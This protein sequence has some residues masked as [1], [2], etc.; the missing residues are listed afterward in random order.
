[1]LAYRVI[2]I[3]IVKR[4]SLFARAICWW[5]AYI[6]ASKLLKWDA[7]KVVLQLSL[8]ITEKLHNDA[9]SGDGRT[10]N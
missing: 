3:Q 6:D 5:I 4:A 1:M 2:N 9:S 10:P 8:N 7:E